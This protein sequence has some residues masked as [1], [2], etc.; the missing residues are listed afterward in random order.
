MMFLYLTIDSSLGKVDASLLPHQTLMELFVEKLDDKKAF[1]TESG[2]FLPLSD[3]DGVTLD[4]TGNVVSID[5]EVRFGARG[6]MQEI[7]VICSGGSI[8]LQWVPPT[9]T[10][11]SI[12][13]R[14]LAGNID[15]YRL[16]RGLTLLRA[17]QNAFNGSLQ[18]DGLPP[19]LK[20]LELGENFLDGTVDLTTLPESMEFL[21]AYSNTLSGTLDFGQL[22]RALQYVY[23]SQNNFSGSVD[24]SRLP[25]GMR[26]ISIENNPFEQEWL[27]VNYHEVKEFTVRIDKRK[28]QSVIDTNGN[29]VKWILTTGKSAYGTVC[30][31]KGYI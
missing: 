28:I 12:S 27:I 3:W 31:R 22:P 18:T 7:H 15:S 10:K 11:I 26:S 6:L 17:C 21:S 16:P 8:D 9:V 13:Q 2:D 25:A 20:K 1:R 24:L 30:I 29:D 4:T 23:L 5:W 19:T 14:R